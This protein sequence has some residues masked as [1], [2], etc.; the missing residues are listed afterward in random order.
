[1]SASVI[2]SAK[3]SCAG[4]PEKLSSGRT[5]IETAPVRV[6]AAGL[7]AGAL[8]EGSGRSE[9]FIRVAI[10][11]PSVTV[12]AAPMTWATIRPTKEIQA[13]RTLFRPFFSFFRCRS[14]SSGSP[15]GAA[16]GAAAGSPVMTP[17]L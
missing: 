11:T 4:S 9:R 7:S 8:D 2:P 14:R 17:T 10:R 12:A 6:R 15:G 16:G 1:M 5:A 13:D 3:Y